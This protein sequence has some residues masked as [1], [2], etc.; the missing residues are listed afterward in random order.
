MDLGL[1]GPLAGGRDPGRGEFGRVLLDPEV[2]V[3]PVHPEA[4]GRLADAVALFVDQ[5]DGGD[6]ELPRVLPCHGDLLLSRA[7]MLSS[8][9]VH[10]SWGRPHPTLNVQHPTSNE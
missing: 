5:P 3:G 6:L 9:S 2:D 4:P 7:I 8:R 10:H 1:Q